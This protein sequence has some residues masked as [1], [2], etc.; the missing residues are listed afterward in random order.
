[1]SDTTHPAEPE[2]TPT[3]Q[4]DPPATDQPPAPPAG[5]PEGQP[6]DEQ[7]RFKAPDEGR[8]RF[9]RR[10]GVFR[11]QVTQLARER[12]Q[13]AARLAAL[14]QGRVA[15]QPQVDPQLQAYIE[16]QAEQLAERKLTDSRVKS[17]HEAGAQRYPDWQ[18]RCTDL[19]AM[20]ADSQFAQ[21][22]VKMPEG[23]KVAGAL[24]D[25]PEEV[26]RIASLAPD[27]RAFALGQ[28]AAR[29]EAAPTRQVSRAP[30]PP[31]PLPGR[32]APQPDPYRMD[33]NDLARLWMHEALEAQKRR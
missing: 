14:E 12:D 33:A 4:P 23:A 11:A 7:G 21:L 31:K 19:Q 24:R 32:S 13:F 6:R 22:L 9:D 30:A 20:G 5:E 26:E 18:Q 17:F 10:L 16:Q 1:M 25:D 8:A 3:P 15:G 29:L 28:Y 27:D 2:P